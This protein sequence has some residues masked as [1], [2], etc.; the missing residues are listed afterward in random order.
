M[1]ASIPG[2]DLC[3]PGIGACIRQA[4]AFGCAVVVLA[5]CGGSVPPGRTPASEAAPTGFTP[6]AVDDRMALLHVPDDLPPGP[7]A[8]V[9]ALHGYTSDAAEVVGYFRLRDL[10][11]ERGFVVVAPQG[12]TD[13]DGER[14]WNASQAC[15]DFDA[16][17][18]DDSAHL[19]R[20]LDVVATILPV[21]PARVFVVGHSNGAF[22][23]HRLAC[24]HADQ[25]AAIV[26]LAGALDA[27][28]ACGPSRPVSVLQ[29]H[30]V[31]DDSILY[32]GGAIN[33]RRYTSARETAAR[34]GLANGCASDGLVG[35]PVDGA[36]DV[37][38]ADL[39]PTTWD[40]C[41]EGA[42]VALWTV[43]GGAH[44][45]ALTPT[46]TASFVDWLEDHARHR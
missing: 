28:A 26:S 19:S 7:A 5:G 2:R 30:G 42:A 27:E 38:G 9:M 12:T 6:L 24:E 3:R 29:V 32:E 8:V 46:A 44:V 40:A 31:A 14:F 22:M 35:D 18:V 20:V 41:R 17:G 4:V 43:E 39:T 37:S 13:A 21:D 16:T 11:D 45:P 1:L 10:A 36:A 15:C 34:W 23:A 33:G 25:V